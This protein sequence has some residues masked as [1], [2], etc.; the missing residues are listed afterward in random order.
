MN[1]KVKKII[2]RVWSEDLDSEYKAIER[3]YSETP[4][5]PIFLEVGCGDLG[6]LKRKGLR[7][8]RLFPNS[9]GVD[10]DLKAL[11][12]NRQT[13][14]RVCSDCYSLPIRSESVDIVVCRWLVEHLLDPQK[15]LEEFARILKEDGFL[16]LTTPNL[17]NYVAI[18]SRLTPKVLH[19]KLRILGGSHEN[20][21]TYYKANT[22]W[23]L[24]TLADRS[25]FSVKR[26]EFI[27]H[28]FLYYSFSRP[29]FL[30]MMAFSGLLSR[31]YPQLHLKINCLMQKTT[32]N[33]LDITTS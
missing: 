26:I 30:I 18:I 11:A 16:F 1:Q 10:V 4:E 23:K 29:M 25:G 6:F 7:L 19:D 12:Q 17:L 32:Q 8:E 15:A 28:S 9:I 33:P 3:S 5:P 31:L 20:G 27:P 14:F 24:A 22:K 13:R 2:E 21:S